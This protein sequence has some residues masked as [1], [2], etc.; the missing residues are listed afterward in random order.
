MIGYEKEAYRLLS[1]CKTYEILKS[2]PLPEFQ[3]ELKSLVEKAAKDDILCKS[4]KQFLLPHTCSTPYFYHL[5]KG[6]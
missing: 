5:P 2:D 6:P 3:T 1:D 4:E